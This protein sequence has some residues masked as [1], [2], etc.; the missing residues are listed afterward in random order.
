MEEI[1]RIFSS[2]INKHIMI[3]II[4]NLEHQTT[5]LNEETKSV[6]ESFG[7]RHD[8]VGP[9]TQVSTLME[10]IEEMVE[11]N[12]GGFYSTETFLEAQMSKM[13]KFEEMKK[14]IHSL[15]THFLS[16]GSTESR[17]DLRIVLQ[18]TP[19]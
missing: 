12:Q 19:S 8:F 16:Q 4:Q 10:N 2:R 17:D 7:G 6:I 3:L 1:Q 5:E 15:E 18:E 14:K 11:E 9:A 13:L